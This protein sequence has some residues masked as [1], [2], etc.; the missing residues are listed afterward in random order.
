MTKDMDDKQA[1][2][3]VSKS[4]PV[5]QSYLDD[6]L[7][8]TDQSSELLEE[9]VSQSRPPEEPKA[10]G[11]K[12]K[13][14]RAQATEA[15]ERSKLSPIE[16]VSAVEDLKLPETATKT[17][18]QATTKTDTQTE[19]QKSQQVALAQ[20]SNA[21]DMSAKTLAESS[22]QEASLW[23][24]N[25]FDCLVFDTFGVRLAAPM[26]SLGGIHQ[27]CE[28]EK[29]PLFGQPDWYLGVVSIH[30]KQMKLLDTSLLL[31]PE[32][33]E[34]MSLETAKYGVQLNK[35]DWCLACDSLSDSI[36]IESYKIHWRKKREQ[37]PWFIGTLKD[38]MC[39]L[40]DVDR[41]EQHLDEIA[42]KKK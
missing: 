42:K 39:S 28:Y 24:Q 15:K 23:Q 32:R 11:S 26:V 35:S 6:L 34:K 7:T 18:T 25:E 16:Q 27:L 8:R 4:T 2:R 17:A 9:S 29:A 1:C 31:M 22:V 5:V 33:G 13:R 40:I 19:T 36:M 20:D 38:F 41:L 12:L 14:L 30:G 10:A 21:Q 37:R 3:V